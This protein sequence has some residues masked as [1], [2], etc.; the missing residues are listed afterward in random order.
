MNCQKLFNKNRSHHANGHYK[1]SGHLKNNIWRGVGEGAG[2]KLR[3]RDE[4]QEISHV[5]IFA[6][7]DG[8]A[9][10]ANGGR[11]SSVCWT[12]ALLR[13]GVLDIRC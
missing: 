3:G 7:S 4:G 11:L 8:P 12:R 6:V 13:R 10:K 2:S 9:L 5:S 1:Y